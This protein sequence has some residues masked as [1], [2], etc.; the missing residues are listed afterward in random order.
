MMRNQ[1]F[2][3]AL[4]LALVQALYLN[5]SAGIALPKLMPKLPPKS[6][7]QA[8]KVPKPVPLIRD[9]WAVLVG[10]SK[11]TDPQI[12]P[13]KYASRNVLTLTQ[14]L[15]DAN[16]GRFLPNHVLVITEG[17]ATKANL[18]TAVWE[19]WLIKKALPNDLIVIYLC[20]RATP[21]DDG[22]DILLLPVDASLSAKE[23]TA[24][25]LSGLLGEVKRRTQSKNILCLLD[26][27]SLSEHAAMG[28][29]LKTI[30]QTTGT[31]IISAD[32]AVSVSKDDEN[33]RA[34][35]F[36][37]SLSEGVK[38]GG[39]LL[40]IDVV[41]GF[42]AETLAKAGAQKPLVLVN[43]E[44]PDLTRVAIGLPIIKPGFDPD[45]VKFGH[46]MTPQE[47]AKYEQS[48]AAPASSVHAGQGQPGQGHPGQ[49]DHS[50]TASASSQKE[51]AHKETA[52]KEAEAD[53]EDEEEPADIDYGPYMA[54]MKKTIQGKWSP[55]K[56]T[57]QKT[58]IAV[59][60][61]LRDGK[62]DGPEIVESSGK[63]EVDQSALEA[64][65][66]AS[67][68]PPLPKGSPR[69]VQIRYKFDWKTTVTH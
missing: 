20:L 3:R 27:Q 12:A 52:R 42:I 7:P 55:P 2:L 45:K 1:T 59:F 38:A 65:K 13:I 31:T 69:H 49:A 9:K 16:A 11:W 50:Q 40:P 61:I 29:L 41:S 17:K 67:P 46:P 54:N 22:S 68:L 26:L 37:S 28:N 66:A 51:T 58:V 10:V 30:S 8:K 5:C 6:A 47:R 33:A 25:S 53:D 48:D 62:I 32:E 4:S 36:A 14:T 35:L 19:D 21:T 60:S 43:P 18:A 56:D 39:G 44:N 15:C 64:L 24:A 23:N 63:A 57:E 34:S